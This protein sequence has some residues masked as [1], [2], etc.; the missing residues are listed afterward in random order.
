YNPNTYSPD[1]YNMCWLAL[2]PQNFQYQL[3]DGEGFVGIAAYDW[4]G[5][6]KREFVACKLLD[7]LEFGKSY[8]VSF[9]AR[10]FHARSR[11][12][13]NNLGIHFSDTALQVNDTYVFNLYAPPLLEAQVKYF[14]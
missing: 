11:F 1:Y 10:I 14:N 13:S 6:N 8:K 5:S 3:V 2:P 7:T 12:A 9:Y 4:S